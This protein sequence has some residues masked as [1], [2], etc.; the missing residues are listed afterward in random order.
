MT[1]P[2]QSRY[3]ATEI[4]FNSGNTTLSLSSMSG[5]TISNQVADRAVALVNARTGVKSESIW[6]IITSK[7]GDYPYVKLSRTSASV[8]PMAFDVI[9]GWL[10][11][12]IMPY[13]QACAVEVSR[14]RSTKLLS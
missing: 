3:G 1:W 2:H 11:K 5:G 13:G 7:L 6:N 9:D 10:P 12:K 8:D 14:Y 4:S